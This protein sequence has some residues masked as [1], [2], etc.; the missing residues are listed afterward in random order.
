[1]PLH[2]HRRQ[3]EPLSET[4]RI[5]ATRGLSRRDQTATEWNQI[6]FSDE[7]RF[8]LGSDD[9][10]IRVW[11]PHGECLN[12]VPSLH[13]WCDGMGCHRIRL[14]LIH[15]TMTA[16][17]YVRD[18]LQPHMFLL[19]AGHPGA[20]FQQ[21]MHTYTQNVFTGLLPP[22]LASSIPRF[23][24]YRTYLGSFRMARRTVY[25]FGRIID[26]FAVN[27]KR[28]VTGHHTRLVCQNIRPYHTMHSC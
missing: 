10:R 17:K 21:D 19:M 28:D 22:S 12:P 3:H 27:V 2:R 5:I 13:N 18:I 16:Q 26:A 6:V 1:M 11:K 23:L 15:S 20:I 7:S 9:N 14:I 4:G 24:T 25:E 8:N